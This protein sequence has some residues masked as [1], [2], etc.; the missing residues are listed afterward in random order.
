MGHS[1]VGIVPELALPCDKGTELLCFR[2][3]RPSAALSQGAGPPNL[4]GVSRC[5]SFHFCFQGNAPLQRDQLQH[6]QQLGMGAPAGQVDLGIVPAAPTT[7]S[8]QVQA[9]E[10]CNMNM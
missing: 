7:L 1:E 5:G 4:P 3:C 10:T 2:V 9:E 6:L 8:H